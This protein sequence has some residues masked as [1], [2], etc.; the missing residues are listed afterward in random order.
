MAT[1]I[2]ELLDE[3]TEEERRTLNYAFENLLAQYILMP[4]GRYI[5]V[6]LDGHPGLSEPD[7]RAGMWSSGI[8]VKVG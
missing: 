6:H 3:L 2:K 4:D 8:C 1:S 7:M 5:G